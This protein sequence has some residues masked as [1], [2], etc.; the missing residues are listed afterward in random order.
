MGLVEAAFCSLALRWPWN[1]GCTC[2]RVMY[3]ARDERRLTTRDP[4]RWSPRC[5]SPMK[6]ASWSNN[7][8]RIGDMGLELRMQI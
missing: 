8:H 2:M 1:R 5:L 6:E 3:Q 4:R 7:A